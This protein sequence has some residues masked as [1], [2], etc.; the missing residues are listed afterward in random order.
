MTYATAFPD[1]SAADLPAPFP[2]GFEDISWHND[3]CPQ[4]WAEGLRLSLWI[5]YAD[6]AL[7]E[8][9][10]LRASGDLGR[11]SIMRTEADTAAPA[12]GVPILQS[13]EWRDVLAVVIGEKFAALLK[14]YATPEQ[15]AVMRLENAGGGVY[16]Q[17]CCASHNFCDANMPMDE[18]F[19][20]V[21]GHSPR[22]DETEHGAEASAADCALWG[23]AWDHA[24]A[25]HFTAT[26]QEVE[27]DAKA[28]VLED[29]ADTLETAAT[30]AAGEPKSASLM[31]KADALRV[32]A[33]SLREAI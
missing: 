20:E 10:D 29:R 32:E 6:A 22:I 16:A 11:F 3:A 7:S 12:P 4:F 33:S 31:A 21:M 8:F 1:F 14:A 18:A 2:K 13:D 26:P 27:T 24:K 30:H 17:G 15:W 23:K 28:S 25:A 5:D 9:P 19:S